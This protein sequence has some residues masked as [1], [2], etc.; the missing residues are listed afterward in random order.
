M[1]MSSAH[2]TGKKTNKE[3]NARKTTRKKTETNTH[4]KK[5]KKAPRVIRI[6][7]FFYPEKW[8]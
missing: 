5:S 1:S 4:R 7:S 6:D 2:H 3:E 8:L